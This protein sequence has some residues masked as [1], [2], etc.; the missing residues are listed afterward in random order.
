MRRVEIAFDE[1]WS[2]GGAATSTLQ[3]EQAAAAEVTLRDDAVAGASWRM[4]QTYAY[5][6]SDDDCYLR[7]VS[8]VGYDVLFDHYDASCA[9]TTRGR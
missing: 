4:H 2:R 6:A 1:V 9:G 3:N 8:S 7:N 5:G